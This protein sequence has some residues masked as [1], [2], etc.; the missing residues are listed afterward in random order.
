[1]RRRSF[2][3][4]VLEQVSHA[5]FAV[6]LMPRSDEYGQVDCHGGFR[7]V[8]NQQNL[9]AVV[10]NVLSNAFDRR[11]FLWRRRFGCLRT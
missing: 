9:E 8:W 4:H 10:E 1:M 2:E 6:A 11:D 5:C 7:G 3:E